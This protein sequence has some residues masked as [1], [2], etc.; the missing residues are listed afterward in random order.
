MSFLDALLR[1]YQETRQE[2]RDFGRSTL[3]ALLISSFLLA[4]YRWL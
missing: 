2:M 4:I 3:I 1:H